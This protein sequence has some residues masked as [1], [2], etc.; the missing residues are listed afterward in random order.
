LGDGRN[1]LESFC[2]PHRVASKIVHTGFVVSFSLC[3]AVGLW[4]LGP[5]NNP[6]TFATKVR[7]S[8]ELVECD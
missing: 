2:A 5:Q 1:Q 6:A 8:F 4:L 7:D 3:N